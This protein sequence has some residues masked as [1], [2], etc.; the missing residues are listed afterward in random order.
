M[1]A[2]LLLACPVGMKVMKVLLVS[3][4]KQLRPQSV[5][6]LPVHLP[7][8]RMKSEEEELKSLAR[9]RVQIEDEGDLSF[10]HCKN[11]YV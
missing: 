8:N 1:L 6:G 9:Y 3:H 11:S 4:L 10:K 5:R 7:K 2:Y